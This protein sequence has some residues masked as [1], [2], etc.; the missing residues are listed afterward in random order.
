MSN[1]IDTITSITNIRSPNKIILLLKS[2]LVDI[3]PIG[4]MFVNINETINNI[5]LAV[6][7]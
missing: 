6:V 2:T 3:M 7:E 1:T 5:L 4:I